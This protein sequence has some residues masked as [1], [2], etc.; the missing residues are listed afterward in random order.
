MVLLL[1]RF[2]RPYREMFDE[3]GLITDKAVKYTAGE[4]ALSV[5]NAAFGVSE[6]IARFPVMRPFLLFTKTPTD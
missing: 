5:D 2:T 6:L 3:D 1:T 4:I